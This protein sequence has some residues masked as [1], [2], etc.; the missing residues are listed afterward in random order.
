MK[1]IGKQR[2]R[3]KTDEEDEGTEKKNKEATATRYNWWYNSIWIPFGRSFITL[4]YA[5]MR[6]LLRPFIIVNAAQLK[7]GP[8]TE[9]NMKREKRRYV[10]VRNPC[11]NGFGFVGYRF[12]GI[13]LAMF[14]LSVQ[15]NNITGLTYIIDFNRRIRK[16]YID[17]D[18][19]ISISFP[20]LAINVKKAA[21]Y[22]LDMSSIC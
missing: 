16:Y 6:Y 18:R 19:R 22:E 9:F 12:A 14:K 5:W 10:W 13:I 11:S 15:R 2:I 7:N 4:S 17:I 20:L 3:Q 1:L 8:E 21:S